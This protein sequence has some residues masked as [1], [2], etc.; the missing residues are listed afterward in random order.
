MIKLDPEWVI[1]NFSI[2]Q[3]VD[4][5]GMMTALTF[6]LKVGVFM[7]FLLETLK[8]DF[9]VDGEVGD[10]DNCSFKFRIEDIKIDFP[11]LYARMIRLNIEF[12]EDKLKSVN[13]L[14]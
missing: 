9:D 3:H 4:N 1:E 7:Q 13:V 6:G 2:S 5:Y 12:L 8:I 10:N 14:E 11:T